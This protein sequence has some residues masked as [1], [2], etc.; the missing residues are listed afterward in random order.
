MYFRNYLRSINGPLLPFYTTLGIVCSYN[1]AR[2]LVLDQPA[3]SCNEGQAAAVLL[4]CGSQLR[5]VLRRERMRKSQFFFKM[6]LFRL[7]LL[8]TQPRAK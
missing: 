7:I 5:C 2:E 1:R 8:S 4:N 3:G 6:I